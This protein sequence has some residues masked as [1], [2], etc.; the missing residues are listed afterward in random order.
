MSAVPLSV[1]QWRA[2]ATSSLARARTLSSLTL[3]GIP[4][5]NTLEHCDLVV[6]LP[7]EQTL[8]DDLTEYSDQSADPRANVNPWR[9]QHTP[10]SQHVIA[11]IRAFSESFPDCICQPNFP[12]LSEDVAEPNLAYLL[13]PT[14]PITTDIFYKL[15]EEIAPIPTQQALTSVHSP[16]DSPSLPQFLVL[17]TTCSTSAPP[18]TI[19]LY[20]ISGPSQTSPDAVFHQNQ[21]H[22]LLLSIVACKTHSC[23]TFSPNYSPF[24]SSLQGFCKL[25]KLHPPMQPLLRARILPLNPSLPTN[26][27]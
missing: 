8:F 1:P 25:V 20:S 13:Q 4:Y 14:V 9:P 24:N 22:Y 10:F 2:T 23:G 6:V 19:P 16:V 26:C 27:P 12:V 7:F 5:Q 21:P 15:Q 18:P 3:N 11:R 17:S